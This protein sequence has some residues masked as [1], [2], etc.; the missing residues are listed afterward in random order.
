MNAENIYG[1]F[2]ALQP[3]RFEN[4][5]TKQ[6]GNGFCPCTVKKNKISYIYSTDRRYPSNA[7]AKHAHVFCV[8]AFSKTR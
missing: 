5:L 7:N 2:I 6:T 4:Q 1:M 8:N 3:I